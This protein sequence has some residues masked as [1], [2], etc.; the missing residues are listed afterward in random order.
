VQVRAGSSKQ[1][2]NCASA[3]SEGAFRACHGRNNAWARRIGRDG[4]IPKKLGTTHPRHKSP[5]LGSVLQSLIAALILSVF[6][7]LGAYPVMQ[8]FSWFSNLATLCLILLMATTSL[9]VICY[10]RANPHLRDSTFK[11]FVLPGCSGIA[12][13]AI[14]VMALVHFDVLTGTSK[15]LAVCCAASFPRRP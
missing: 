13:L 14:W 9:A 7:V 4:L 15:D 8:L 12:L 5:H 6:A 11:C 3:S 10:F 1:A 2:V